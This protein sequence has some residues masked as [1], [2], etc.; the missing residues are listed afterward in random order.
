MIPRSFPDE[1]P[2]HPPLTEAAMAEEIAEMYAYYHADTSSSEDEFLYPYAGRPPLSEDAP[3]A[4]P[5]RTQLSQLALKHTLIQDILDRRSPRTQPYV[6]TSTPDSDLGIR[7][8]AIPRAMKESH[9]TP[10]EP[11]DTLETTVGSS[12]IEPPLPTLHPRASW[13]I[14]DGDDRTDAQADADWH[15]ANHWLRAPPTLNLPPAAPPPLP[16]IGLPCAPWGVGPV[17][18]PLAAP[19]AAPGW[20]LPTWGDNDNDRQEPAPE[21]QAWGRSRP[22]SRSSSDSC[23]DDGAYDPSLYHYVQTHSSFCGG[24][25]VNATA[26]VR[27]PRNTRNPLSTR[28]LLV[29]L[30]SYSDVTMASRDILYNVHPV[31]EHLSTG[32]G[33]TEYTEEGLV[34]IVD[35]PCSFRTIPALVASQPAHLPQKCLLLL[36]VPQLNELDIKVDTHRTNRRLPLQSYDPT[37]DFS[38][39]THLQCRMSEKDLLAWAEHHKDTPVGFTKYSHHDIVY[40]LDTLSPVELQQLREVSS[41]YKN[42]YDAAKGALPALANHPP[43]T[44]NFGSTFLYLSQMGPRRHRSPH[45]LG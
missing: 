20:L 4:D 45:A 27:D 44:L 10:Y 22:P 16:H 15:R 41:T 40:S 38:A 3:P 30:D 9:A 6:T 34:D 35:G 7:F 17:Y 23:P 18:A 37:I 42:V 39:D 36:G 29:G 8:E 12:S 32:R 43:V 33:N 19:T 14:D 21:P 26:F 13:M 25:T 11:P 24:T 28:P 5:S 1:I 31:L 2:S